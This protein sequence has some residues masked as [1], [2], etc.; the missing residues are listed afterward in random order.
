VAE[1]PDRVF[2]RS[3]VLFQNASTPE[4]Q[5]PTPVHLDRLHGSESPTQRTVARAPGHDLPQLR[6]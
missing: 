4:S 3:F 5:H 2:Y 1:W 6:S